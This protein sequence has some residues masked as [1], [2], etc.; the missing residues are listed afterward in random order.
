MECQDSISVKV[1]FVGA[2]GV[3]KTCIIKRYI[4]G[5]FDENTR[6]SI[7]ASYLVKK[8]NLQNQDYKINVWDTAGQEKYKSLAPMYYRGAFA[9]FI[10]YDVSNTSSLT[11]AES[12][13]K[14]LLMNVPQTLLILCANKI[15]LNNRIINEEGIKLAND[16]NIKYVETS[17]REGIGIDQA[18]EIVYS[19]ILAGTN[20]EKFEVLQKFDS[21]ESSF[22]SCL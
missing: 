16:Y 8:V 21:N 9:S 10:V 11:E 2:P 15:D 12:W 3:G 4:S 1:V 17:A 18:F 13:I 6:P 19:N 7:E 5:E 14:E 20:I 22:C